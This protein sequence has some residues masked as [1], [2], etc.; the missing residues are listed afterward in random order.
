MTVTA[1]SIAALRKVL[2]AAPRVPIPRGPDRIPDPSAWRPR[3]AVLQEVLG[4]LLDL[5]GQIS[6]ALPV[7]SPA[8][9][10][11]LTKNTDDRYGGDLQAAIDAAATLVP[12][13]SVTAPAVV[14]ILSPGEYVGNFV[15]PQSVY[16]TA[17]APGTTLAVVLRSTSGNT[18]TLPEAD[19]GITGIAVISESAAPT[20]AAIS[21]APVPAGG[22]STRI[23]LA[24]ATGVGGAASLRTEVGSGLA[25]GPI[26]GIYL[27]CNGN[28]PV[29][30]DLLGAGMVINL[31]GATNFSPTGTC[32]HASG[33]ASFSLLFQAI[34]QTQAGGSGWMIDA[35]N[36][37]TAGVF[38]GNAV[39]SANCFRSRTGAVVGI[40][41]YNFYLTPTGTLLE[42]D[43]TGLAG[44]GNIQFA[45]GGN[46]Y[47][48]IVAPVPA[49]VLFSTTLGWREGLDAARPATPQPGMRY[50]ATDRPAGSRQLT[51]VPSLGWVDQTDTVV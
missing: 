11:Y 40:L 30:L 5:Q 27:D 25:A 49:N 38:G 42:L 26:V 8:R 4:D 21:I 22:D 15:V 33:A 7:V 46:P 29:L 14:E 17:V 12:P 9:R 36:G 47:D 41:D 28:S 34:L 45:T 16:L 31:G 48:L 32:I 19:S 1:A 20:D 39:I 37:A 50:Y 6:A 13:P 18:L 44:L 51:W 3:D 2:Q 35:E 23:V 43:A 10:I 24:R